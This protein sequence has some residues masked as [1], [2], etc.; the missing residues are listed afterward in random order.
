[1]TAVARL[2]LDAN[3]F[4]YALGAD[5]P[6]RAPSRNVLQASAVRAAAEFD[7]EV[8][9]VTSDDVFEAAS[10]KR[11][12]ALVPRR[13][14]CCRNEERASPRASVRRPGLRRDS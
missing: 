3:V 7:A 12:L 5:S 10:W 8:L 13:P 14:A 4:L 1:M 2:F 6:H 9:P 11:T